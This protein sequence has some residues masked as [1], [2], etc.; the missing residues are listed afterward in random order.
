MVNL[1]LARKRVLAEFEE[2]PGM[3][4]TRRQAARLLGLEPET[5]AQVLDALLDA[6]YLRETRRGFIVRGD[7]TAA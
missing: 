6:A 5:C 7:R 4:L 2:M 1:E 3:A